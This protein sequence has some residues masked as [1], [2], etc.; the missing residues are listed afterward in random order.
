LEEK[1]GGFG[2]KRGGER[3]EVVVDMWGHVGSHVGQSRRQNCLKI[4]RVPKDI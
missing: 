4:F 2:R 1:G 3:R